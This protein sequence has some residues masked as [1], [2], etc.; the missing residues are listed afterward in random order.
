MTNP[1]TSNRLE[2]LREQAALSRAGL[3]DYLG[4]GEHQVRRWESGETLIPTKHFPAL[5]AKFGVTVD[6][7]LGMD[8]QSTETPRATA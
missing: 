5:V 3:A 6:Y 4:I 7:L 2:E 1:V 8:R